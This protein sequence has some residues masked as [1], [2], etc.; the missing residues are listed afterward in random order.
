MNLSTIPTSSLVPPVATAIG[1]AVRE[2]REKGYVMFPAVIDARLLGAMYA[3]WEEYFVAFTSRRPEL[4]RWLMHLPFKAPL[5]DPDFVENPLVLDVVDR[6]LGEDCICG[7]F[8]SE[9]PLPGATFQNPHF[10][11]AFLRSRRFLNRPLAFLNRA[12]GSGGFCYGIQVSVPLVDS[13]LENAPFEIWPGSNRLRLRP[14]PPELVVMPAG[15][16][17]VRDIRNLHRGT[18][19]RGTEPRPFLSLV[20]LRPWV[21]AWKPPEIPGAVYDTLPPRSRRLFR[22]A[23]IGHDVPDPQSWARRAR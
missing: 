11:L 16:L 22:M 1:D 17:L 4:K 3:V 19:H 7:Y 21:P 23:S 13:G 9:T 6:M 14:R 18:P 15:S 8:G 20:Y 12:L 2:F 5:Y 10:D